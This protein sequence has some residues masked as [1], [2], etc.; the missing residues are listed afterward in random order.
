MKLIHLTPLC[1]ALNMA[2][3]SAAALAAPSALTVNGDNSAV[4]G[5]MNGGEVNIH[6]GGSLTVFDQ[7]GGYINILAPSLVSRQA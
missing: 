5:E 4:V 2:L 7:R 1:A 6:P 3:I